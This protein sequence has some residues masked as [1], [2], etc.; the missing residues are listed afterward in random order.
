LAI[1]VP[2]MLMSTAMLVQTQGSTL[3]LGLFLGSEDVGHFYV[4]LRLATLLLFG[5]EAINL[6]IAPRFASYYAKN[7][8]ASL[9]RAATTAAVIS[10]SFVVVGG[11]FLVI[12]GKNLLEL[13]G[14]GVDSGYPAL[15]VLV[16]GYL[17]SSCCGSVGF[18]MTMTGNQR[19][20]LNVFIW[21][22]IVHILLC[23]LLIPT[24]G[25]VG[26][27]LSHGITVAVWNIS[28]AYHVKKRLGVTS[29]VRLPARW[30]SPKPIIDDD[31]RLIVVRKAA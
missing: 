1:G 29:Y 30:R 8:F 22:G 28:L 7:D 20:S 25:I 24:L 3:L 9:Q 17:V 19:A 23:V 18:L 16:A 5:S 26:A 15:L 10:A 14:E 31:Q 2:L 13:F 4:V 11:V 27:A 6:V 21:T 12:I